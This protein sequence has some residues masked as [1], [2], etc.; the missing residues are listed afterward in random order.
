MGFYAIS[1]CGVCAVAGAD[2]PALATAV[3]TEVGLSN[4][5][6]DKE[7]DEKQIDVTVR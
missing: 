5:I 3:D 2:D 4:S 1:V 7:V 6:I